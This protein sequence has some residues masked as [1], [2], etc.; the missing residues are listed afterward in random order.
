LGIEELIPYAKGVSA[1]TQKFN[2]EGNETELDFP[3]IFDIIKKSGFNGIVGIEYEG[4]L[5]HMQGMDGYLSNEEG[6][7]ATRKLIEKSVG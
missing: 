7:V 1:K 6:I 2:S 4:V 3:R 5:M